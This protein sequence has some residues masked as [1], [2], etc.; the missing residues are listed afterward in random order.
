MNSTHV[1]SYNI[2]LEVRLYILFV[3][4]IFSLVGN[5]LVIKQLLSPNRRSFPKS[6]LL[7]FNLAAADLLASFGSV[8]FPCKWELMGKQWE[9]GECLCKL[10]AILQ[11]YS[12]FCYSYMLIAISLR[13]YLEVMRNHFANGGCLFASCTNSSPLSSKCYA[14]LSW[15]FALLP[16]AVKIAL[17]ESSSVSA[18]NQIIFLHSIYHRYCLG[19]NFLF[20]VC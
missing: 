9:A 16:V 17:E 6:K 10:F 5:T 2:T 3:M 11:T 13:V 4:F 18:N 15:L 19:D 20:H 7:F 8:L 1:P 14:L 12:R